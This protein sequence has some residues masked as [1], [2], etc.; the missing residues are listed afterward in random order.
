MNYELTP[1]TL[2]Y[3]S[4]GTGFRGGGLEATG[5]APE[6]REYQPETVTNYE[7]GVRSSLMGGKLYLAAT[8]FNMDYKDLQVSSIVLNPLTN[9]VSAVT[10]NA[11]TARLRGIELE[12]IVRPTSNDRISGFV[13]YL[14]AKIRSFPTASDNL[15]SGSGNY[16]GVTGAFGN[17]PLPTNVVRDVSGNELPNALKWSA[18]VS[19]AHIFDL[20]G[21]G[22]LTPSV[23][24]YVQSRTFSDI[25][26]Y[27][28][29]RRASYTK[30]DL[31]L[32][33]ETED[34][35][36]SI[37]GFVNNLEDERVANNLV[38]VW[39]STTANYDPPRTYGVRLGMQF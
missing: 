37:T 1:E 30:T 39:S 36:L 15:N 3:A 19:Y 32:R 23:D 35:Q 6:F 22:S 33:Y 11:A 28:Q 26:N 13:S 12:A 8:A 18:R 27:A 24:F 31:N 2:A 16:N 17:L 4:V 21:A 29:S 14:D 25:Q 38:T 20:G 5:N 10:T 34:G 7:I 9:Q